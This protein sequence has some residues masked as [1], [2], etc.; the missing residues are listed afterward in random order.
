MLAFR[1]AFSVLSPIAESVENNEYFLRGSPV[2]WVLVFLTGGIVEEFWRAV[3]IVSFQG[4]GYS[5]SSVLLLT[6]FAFALAH[7]CGLPSRISPGIP[8]VLT[9]IIVGLMLG[10]LF[11]WSG[12]LVTPCVA[13]IIYFTVSFFL[14]RKRFGGLTPSMRRH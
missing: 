8:S 6:A 14:V 4:N 13:S 3:C 5:R 12:N 11:M 1:H 7:T 2:L 10:G 9:E